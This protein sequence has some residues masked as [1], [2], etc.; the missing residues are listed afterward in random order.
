MMTDGIM[1]ASILFLTIAVLPIFV[2]EFRSSVR[3][4]LT[5]WFVIALHQAVAFTNTFLFVTPGAEKDVRYFHNA[6]EALAQSGDFIFSTGATLYCNMLGVAYRLFGSSL[7][8]GSQLSIL[9][10]AISC[11]VLIKILCLLELSHYKVPTLLIFG[12]LPSMVFLGSVTLRE[13]YQILFFMLATYFGLRILIEKNIRVYGAFMVVSALIMGVLHGGLMIYAVLLIALFMMWNIHPA[14]GWLKVKRRHLLAVL[15]ILALTSSIIFL[16]K[17]Q[18]VDLG[19]LSSVVN[20]NLWDTALR[21]HTRT[22]SVVTRATYSVPLDLS[23]PFTTAHT[24]FV[25][26]MHYLFAPFPWQ[27]ENIMDAGASIEAVLRMVLIC[28]SLKRLCQTRG[29][30]YRLLALMLILFFS[31]SFMWALGTTNYGTALRHNMLSWWILA[32]T[33]VPLLMQTLNRFGSDLIGRKHLRPL[34]PV[35]KTL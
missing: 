4:A 19:V 6:G 10:F 7:L 17:V 21:F 13:S 27:I 30:Q 18:H 2:R 33:G 23:S 29:M 22:G 5:Y 31:M 20:M 26:Y 15:V 16:T 3:L 25:L 32:I 14:S 11:I 1:G 35:E 28:F 24:S 9:M 12:A 34:E 8:L